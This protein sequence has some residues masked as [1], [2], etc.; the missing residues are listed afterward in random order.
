MSRKLEL[1]VRSPESE[2]FHFRS[3]P[4][5]YYRRTLDRHWL[6]S[7]KQSKEDL[8]ISVCSVAITNFAD[9]DDIFAGLTFLYLGSQA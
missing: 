3:G 2:H 7:F 1:Q 5:D 4:L 8:I 6:Y 9:A